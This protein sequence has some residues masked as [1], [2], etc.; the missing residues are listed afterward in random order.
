[1]GKTLSVTMQIT[2]FLCSSTPMRFMIALECGNDSKNKDCRW[3]DLLCSSNFLSPVMKC[4]WTFTLTILKR[5]LGYDKMHFLTQDIHR[6]IMVRV[7]FCSHELRFIG[8]ECQYFLQRM[9][10]DCKDFACVLS[11]W[12]SLDCILQPSWEANEV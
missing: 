8:F 2:L 12:D 7:K 1:M 4:G 6:G 11:P 5:C 10:H 3:N 9:Q